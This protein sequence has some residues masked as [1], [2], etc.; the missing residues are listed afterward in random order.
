M[1]IEVTRPAGVA[2][3]VS[4]SHKMRFALGTELGGV[5]AH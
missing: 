5:V 2:D 3:L 1:K 4:E